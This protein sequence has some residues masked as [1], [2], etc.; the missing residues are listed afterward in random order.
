MSRISAPCLLIA[1]A[2]DLGSRLAHLRAA[3]GDEVIAMRRRER[4]DSAGIRH[5]RA[6]LTDGAGFERLP[7]RPDAVVFCAAPDRRNE[8]AYRA[9]YVDG[10]RRLLNGIETTRLIFVSST[11]VYAQ[12]AGEWIDERSPADA[13]SFNGAALLA[14]ESELSAHDQGVVLRLSGIYGPGR[15]SM[16]QRARSGQPGRRHWSNR[17]HVDDAAGALSHLLS[18][19]NPDALYLGNDNEPALEAEVFA[20]IRDM[21]KLARV[22][23]ADTPLSGRRVNNRR[24][25]DTGWA[26]AFPDFRSGFLQPLANAG[27]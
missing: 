25:R 19:P 22:V 20:W 3:R 1:G 16:L 24:L 13:E 15:E 17:I 26:P 12:D 21:E 7:K 14:A 8:A 18:I 10:L 6:D 27:V 23:A 5:I 11:A 4:T 2:G 9:L